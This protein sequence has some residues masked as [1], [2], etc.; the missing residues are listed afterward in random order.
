MK[1]RDHCRVHERVGDLEAGRVARHVVGARG[2]RARQ[3]ARVAA[4]EQAGPHRHREPLVGVEGQRVG[5]LEAGQQAAQLGHQ[6]RGAA[7]GGV[8]VQPQLLAPRQ[9]PELGQGVDGPGAGGARGGHDQEGQQ[10]LRAVVPQLVQER[11]QV[12]PQAHVGRHRPAGRGPQAAQPRGLGEGVV[13]LLGDVEDGLGRQGPRPPLGELRE[14]RV[15]GHQQAAVVGLGPARAEDAVD[16][17]G[18]PAEARPEGPAQVGLDLGREGAVAPG[19]DLRVEGRHQRVGCDAHG[20]G[21]RVEEPEVARVRRVDLLARQPPGG[22]VEGRLGGQ[23]RLEVEGRQLRA[24]GLGVEHR[25]HGQGV[26][27]GR[28]ALDGLGQPAPQLAAQR[29]V[30]VEA[31]GVVHAREITPAG[32]L[33]QAPAA[34]RQ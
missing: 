22:E 24:Q 21:G 19:R 16:L 25:R 12:H 29:G 18:G 30:E 8:H 2:E 17:R 5:L 28:V 20:A 3:R 34:A 7:P 11:V 4:Q 26:H 27:T 9:R 32:R 15:E 13:G 6:R 14:G 10:A 1:R 31:R 23:R 33:S